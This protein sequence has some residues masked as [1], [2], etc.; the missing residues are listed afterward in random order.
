M[1]DVPTDIPEVDPKSTLSYRSLRAV[2]IILGVLIVLALVLVVVGIGMRM[3]GHVPG[4]SGAAGRYDLPAGAKI[5]STQVAGN[6][7]VMTV[8]TPAGESVYIFSASDG[9]LVG[10]IAPKGP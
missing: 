7:L 2:V 10:V 9:H 6:N 5:E 8:Q 1:T 4:Q 3:S